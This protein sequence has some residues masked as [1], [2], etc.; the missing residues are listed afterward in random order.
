MK[1]RQ[2]G[3]DYHWEQVSKSLRK[4]NLFVVARYELILDSIGGEI[5]GK[6]I[7]D[8][9]CGDGVL[10]YLLAKKGAK[11]AGVDNSE[12]A[13][14]SAKEKCKK[15]QNVEFLKG[16]VYESPFK[17]KSFDYIV[18]SEIIE[19]LKYPDKMLSE[20]K[21]AWNRRGKLIITTPMK[22]TENP[23]DTMHYQEF[24]EEELSQLLEK[25]FRDI[26]IIK[27]HPLFWYELQNKPV[28]GRSLIKLFLN[29][30]NILFSFNPFMHIKGWRYYTLQTAI[31][32]K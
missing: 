9:G 30:L 10:V 18:C 21:R 25:Y 6:K 19:H 4:R 29:F 24:F 5:K 22:F 28:L 32:S 14:I 15:L 11:V 8:V 27:S 13:I 20:I 23:L 12:E 2:R 7:L 31:I 26:K 3:A 1:I 17:D 16:S